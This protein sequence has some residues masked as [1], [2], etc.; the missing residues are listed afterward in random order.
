[1]DNI[2][3]KGIAGAVSFKYNHNMIIIHPKLQNSYPILAQ[4]RQLPTP[5]DSV[6]EMKIFLIVVA[7][8]IVNCSLIIAIYHLRV[9]I[10]LYLNILEVC[11]KN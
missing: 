1:M 2:I 5:Y 7:S 10:L 9:I 8:Y 3:C 4:L 11:D 6:I